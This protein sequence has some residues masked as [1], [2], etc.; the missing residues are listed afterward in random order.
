MLSRTCFSWTMISS[1]SAPPNASSS[2]AVPNSPTRLS[3]DRLRQGDIVTRAF[4]VKV[5]RECIRRW[6]EI[7]YDEYYPGKREQMTPE[8]YRKDVQD[9]M[10]FVTVNYMGYRA[11]C[12]FPNLPRLSR[13]A[14][15][16]L[17]PEL[18]W[19]FVFKDNS[20][21]EVLH[22]PLDPADVKGVK[23][24]LG[25]KKQRAQWYDVTRREV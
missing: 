3:R 19:L 2:T 20:S 24:F 22:A 7:V 12:E 25:V 21:H 17:C 11:Y 6:A 18:T 16:V 9:S 5:D 8:E 4:A 1:A 13:C 23:E 10:E 15:L 14:L